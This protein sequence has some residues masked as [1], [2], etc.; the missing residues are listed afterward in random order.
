[1][2]VVGVFQHRLP[3]QSLRLY[4]KHKSPAHLPGLLCRFA[5][6]HGSRHDDLRRLHFR[7]IALHEVVLVR[8][9]GIGPEINPLRHADRHVD[10]AVTARQAVVVVPVGA[11]NGDAVVSEEC[12][13]RYAG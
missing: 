8:R 10:A 4:Y 6:P 5:Y 13:P 7:Q 11:V 12:V 3:Y 9:H 2:P 1:M